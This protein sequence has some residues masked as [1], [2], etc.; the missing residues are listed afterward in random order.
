MEILHYLL[1]ESPEPPINPSKI[2]MSLPVRLR[3]LERS[4]LAGEI[5]GEAYARQRR[6]LI[7]AAVRG[8]EAQIDK[9]SAFLSSS[10][11]LLR[12]TAASVT[13]LA[14]TAQGVSLRIDGR[15]AVLRTC[16]EPISIAPGDRVL[17]TGYEGRS[18]FEASGYLNETTGAR[19]TN[20]AGRQAREFL[21]AGLAGGFC[22][23]VVI[24]AAAGAIFRQPVAAPAGL[25][26]N[27]VLY[28][29]A[30]AAAV[31]LM[32]LAVLPLI[33]SRMMSSAYRELQSEIELATARIPRLT[34]PR[35][36]WL[37]L[38]G[39]KLAPVKVHMSIPAGFTG[40][41]RPPAPDR[42]LGNVLRS[43]GNARHV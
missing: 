23:L 19:S 31:V 32:A 8:I 42:Q 20:R 7:D 16:G 9:P 37:M 39:H 6:K 28:L 40:A 11:K 21:A 41:A 33:V 24:G 35:Y 36:L 17:L 13:P 3:Q 2:G 18:Q 14:G 10:P 22:G 26:A 4:M 34:L 12:G 29:G 25:L 1:R 30:I 5:R 43:A 38:R 27:M 15:R